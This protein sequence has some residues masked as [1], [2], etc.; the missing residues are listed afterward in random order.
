MI[1]NYVM[2]SN[3]LLV[4]DAGDR[5]TIPRSIQLIGTVWMCF[6]KIEIVFAREMGIGRC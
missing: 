2:T 5:T 3:Y 4:A 6:W 1:L